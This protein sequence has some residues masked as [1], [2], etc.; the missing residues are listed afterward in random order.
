VAAKGGTWTKSGGARKFVPAGGG[1]AA[2]GGAS[3][4][5]DPN[6]YLASQSERKLEPIAAQ[7]QLTLESALSND[8]Q[9]QALSALVES[10]STRIR[11]GDG[12]VDRMNWDS[13]YNRPDRR[14]MTDT[15]GDGFLVT[16]NFASNLKRDLDA[17]GGSTL[18]KFPTQ[19]GRQ[20]YEVG[21]Y[22]LNRMWSNASPSDRAAAL[23]ASGST[24]A[25]LRELGLSIPQ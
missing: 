17:G 10:T 2:A 9:A 14:M 4:S 1:G 19:V 12:A 7:T 6:T 11:A 18:G 8:Q 22:K 23:K 16:L 13:R 25:K 3:A 15:S 5:L 24:P 20:A 21:K